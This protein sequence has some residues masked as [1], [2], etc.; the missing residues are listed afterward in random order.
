MFK[1][2]EFSS[3]I[4]QKLKFTTLRPKKSQQNFGIMLVIIN[5]SY[6]TNNTLFRIAYLENIGTNSANW[7]LT[8]CFSLNVYGS[9]YSSL[10]KGNMLP[11]VVP[12]MRLLN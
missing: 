4:D 5:F 10:A 1:Y 3:E 9:V 6:N 11:I 7:K 2:D 8:I 12:N